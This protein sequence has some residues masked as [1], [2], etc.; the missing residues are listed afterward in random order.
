M[1]RIVFFI[2]ALAIILLFNGCYS[3]RT[4]QPDTDLQSSDATVSAEA[5]ETTT[6]GQT[7]DVQTY[8]L[9]EEN[10]YVASANTYYCPASQGGMY[11]CSGEYLTYRDVE[12]G[13]CVK[14]CPQEG[15][16][17]N[18]DSCIAYMG[19]AL[20]NLVEYRGA[21]YAIV[22]T[23]KDTLVLLQK[24]L[25]DGSRETFGEWAMETF[26]DTE[27]T[28]TD[29]HMLPPADGKLYYSVSREILDANTMTPISEEKTLYSYQLDSGETVKL[30]ISDFSISGKAGFIVPV[31]EYNYDTATGEPILTCSEL[32]L[33]DP[34]GADYQLIASR[35]RDD[36]V[37]FSDPNNHYGSLCCY[38]CGNTLYTLDADTG[39]VTELL[40]PEDKVVNYW[41]MDNKIFYITN[42]EAAEAYFYYADLHDCI[43]HQLMNDGNTD[44]MVFSMSSEGN[45]YFAADQK[46]LSKADFYAEKY[47]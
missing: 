43:A 27:V 3:I 29:V 34:S 39:K 14:M 25:T 21:L 47:D 36:Y 33:Y 26:S 5:P 31:E 8:T 22:K 12:T 15:C 42:N 7:P 6:E 20:Q 28:D 23:S 38:Q 46:V 17:H 41:L 16:E 13:T 30:P 4:D 10:P 37:A 32:R 40:T 35:D 9:P 18:D 1:K 45:D 24:N 2:Y 11:L 19:G 44:C